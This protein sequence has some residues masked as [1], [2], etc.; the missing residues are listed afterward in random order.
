MITGILTGLLIGLLVVAVIKW[1]AVL[2]FYIFKGIF[3]IAANIVWK[4]LN[5]VIH[6]FWWVCDE[7][8]YLIDKGKEKIVSAV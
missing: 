2:A 7:V 5:A 6:A 8:E 4:I 3:T 1:V